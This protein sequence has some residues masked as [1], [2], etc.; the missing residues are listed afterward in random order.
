MK[1]PT[2]TDKVKAVVRAKPDIRDQQIVMPDIQQAASSVERGRTGGLMASV[3]KQ[4]YQPREGSLVVI[5]YENLERQ[6]WSGVADIVGFSGETQGGYRSR[7]PE[8]PL[9]LADLAV[10]AC[11]FVT[12]FAKL[13]SA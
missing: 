5:N 10:I 12:S 2:Q 6:H 13:K 1:Q 8:N 3:A 9:N 7:N 4:F 11:G